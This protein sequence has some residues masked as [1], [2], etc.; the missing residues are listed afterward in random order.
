[1]KKICFHIFQSRTLLLSISLCVSILTFAVGFTP[2]DCGLVVNLKPG[3]QIL[4][5]TMVDTDGD[6]IAETEYFV[7]DYPFHSG[8]RFDYKTGNTLKLIPQ[9][10]GATEPSSVSVWS[11]DTALTRVR[12]E[13]KKDY[14]LGGISYTMW[15]NGSYTL[16]VTA[17]NGFKYQGDLSNDK[18]SSAL[19][20]VVFVIP[21]AFESNTSLDPNNTLGK[22][23]LFDGATGVGF[24]GM[25]YREVFW[26]DIPR[27]NM[28]ISYTNASVLGF[29][30]TLSDYK[31]SDNAETAKPGQA[32]YA[33]ADNK[34]K[35]TKRTLFRLYILNEP[36]NTCPD[37][38]FFAH[39]K[40]D[41]LKYRRGPYEKEKLEWKDS[42]A[43]KKV[44]SMDRLECMEQVGSTTIYKTNLMRMPEKDSAYFYV[45]NRNKYVEE[46]DAVPLG[47]NGAV[48]MFTPLSELRIYALKDALTAFTPLAGAMGRMVVDIASGQDNLGVAFEPAGYFLRTNSGVNVRMVKGD[49]GKWTS[50]EMWTITEE[51]AA[52]AIKATMFSGP[53]FSLEDRGID[54]PGWSTMV[55]GT[56]VP[57]STGGS[58]IGVSGWAQ[59]DPSNPSANGGMVFVP[60]DK[61]KYISYNNNG[62]FGDSV[63]ETHP[64]LGET[65]VEVSAPRLIEGYRFE[66]WAT[67]PEGTGILYQEGDTVDVSG[68]KVTLYAKAEYEGSINIAISF[69]HPVDGKRYFLTHPGTAAPRYARARHIAD[70]TNT[71]QGM[72][73]AENV[74]PNYLTSYLIVG[75]NSI[76][77]E[78]ADGEYVFDPHRMTVYGHEDSLTFYEHF[79]PNTE[80]YAGLYYTYPNTILANNTWAGLFKSSKGWPEPSHPCIENTKLSSTHYLHG[81]EEKIT[82]SERSNSDAPNISYNAAANQFDGISGTGTDFTLSG[83]GVVDAHYVILPDTTEEWPAD[84]TF[85]YHEG[86]QTN[87]PVW[88]KLI[89]KQLLAQMMLGNE[90]IYFHPNNAKT[91]TTA[92]ELRLSLDYRLTQTFTYI[93]DARV[94]EQHVV[95]A[96]DKPQMRET[97]NDFQRVIVSG[98]NSPKNVTYRGNYIDMCDTIRIRLQPMG[99]SRIKEYYGWWKDGAEGLHIAADGSRYRDIIVRTKTYHYAPAETKIVLTPEY[100][101]YALSPLRD[102]KSIIRFTMAKVT[103]H[104]LLDTENNPIREE[105]ITSEDLTSE[106]RLANSY[107]SFA[108]GGRYYSVDAEGTLTRNVTIVTREDNHNA[109]NADTL[110]VSG[111]SI[112]IDGVNYAI[113]E[114]RVPLAQSSLEKNELI[115]SAEYAG[116]RYFIMAG[117]GSNELI[118]RQYTQRGNTLYQLNTYNHLR[119]GSEDAA[120]SNT[121][122]I[123]PWKFSYV[124]DGVTDGQTLQR[125]KFYMG[126]EYG[127]NKGFALDGGTTP[128]ALDG[129]ESSAS[130]LTYRY[131]TVYLNTNTNFEER[132]RIKY[133]MN[134]WL[135]FS[136]DGSGNPSLSLQAD[137]T[138]ATIFSWGYL[139]EEYNLQNNGAYPDKESLEFTY[140]SDPETSEEQSVKAQYKAYRE[141]T[142]L[143]N[144]TLTYCGRDERTAWDMLI[145]PKASGGEWLTML[146]ASR[147]PDS[148]FAG[149]GI[150]SGLSVSPMSAFTTTVTDTCASPILTSAP[151]TNIVDT[152]LVTLSLQDGAPKYGFKGD[153]SKFKSVDDAQ[154]KIPLIRRTYREEAYDSLVCVVL[155]DEYNYTFPATITET[156]S[157]TFTLKTEHRE[158]THIL[159]VYGESVHHTETTD[160]D[161]AMDLSNPS[162]AEIR[163]VDEYGNTPTWCRIAG[164][165]AN[166]LTMECTESGIRAPRS[167]YLYFAYMVQ[168]DK[169]WRFVNFRITL[170]QPSHFDYANNQVLVPSTGASGDPLVNGRQQVHEN[171][172]ILYY[173][174]PSNSITDPDQDVELPVRERGFYG[175][176]RWYRIGKDVNG[177]DVTDTDVPDSL[178]R[179]VPRN[180]G[181]YNFPYR[182]IGDSV[183]VDPN[184]PSA[185]KK[186][187][188]MGR[189]TVFHYPSRDY[190]RNDPPAKSP[191]VTPPTDKKTLT[192]AVDISNYYDN[193]PLS[194][195]HVNQVDTAVLDTIRII[196]EPTLSLREVF[197][198]HPWTEMA[199]KLEGY[200]DTIASGYRNQRYMEDHTVMAPTGARLLLST[201]QRYNYANLAKGNHSES[202]LGYYMRDD[203]WN[204]A[205]W[206]AERKD[207]MI[208]AAGWDAD[209]NWYTYNPET[210]AYSPCS[211][212]ITEG[213][214]FLNVPAR[215]S[216]PAGKTA[217]TV[218]Y[219]LRARS[220]ATTGT[221]GVNEKSSPGAYW[222][223]IC[224]Y[225]VIYHDPR[226]Y[227]PLQEKTVD[228][229]MKALI[230]NDEIEQHYQV[231]ERLNFDYNRPGSDYQVYPHPLP[232]ADASYGYSYPESSE[233]PNNRYH[234][235]F[236]S[237]FANMGEYGI[238]NRIPYSN[239]WHKM[240]Q[241]G[242]AA[243]GYMIYCDGM[244]SA[245]QVAAISLKAK[246]CEGQKMYFSG[247]VGNPSN[248]SGKSNPNFLFS[249]QGSHNGEDWIDITSYMTGDVPP[250]NKW[251]QIYF[252]ITQEGDYD[253]F[254]VRIYNMSSDNDGNDFIIDDMC[255]FA[256]KPPLIAYQANTTCMNAGENDSITHVV[257]RVDYKGFHTEA[258]NDVDVYYT[259]Q[260][261]EE[262]S[263]DTTY[264]DPMDGYI[265][266]KTSGD[267]RY[268]VVHMPLRAFEPAHEDS[269]F[270]NLSDLVEKFENSLSGTPFREGYIYENLDE[271]IRPVLYLIHKAKMT[272]TYRYKVRMSA[273]FGDLL[274]SICAMTSDLKVSNRM[275]LELNGKEQDAKE[276][277]GMCANTTYDISLRVKGSLL[278]DSLAPAEINGSCVNDWLLYGDTAEA[279]S[280]ATYGYKYSDIVKVITRILR[281][282]PTSGTNA[283]QF[284]RNL[285]EV[286]RN[287]MTRMAEGVEL[288]TEDHPYDVLSRLVNDGKLI[289]YRPK[290]T[291]TATY[292][293]SLQYV[294]FPIVGTGSDAMLDMAVEVCPTPIFVK[295]KPTIGGKAPMIIGG[296]KAGEEL[297]KEPPVIL[298][299]AADANQEIGIRIDSI[300]NNVAIDTITLLSTND[301]EYLQGIH[302]LE[303]TPDRIFR[304]GEANYG[305]YTKGDTLL[306]SPASVNNYTMRPGYSYTFGIGMMTN[307]GSPTLGESECRVGTVPFTLS[308]VPD[309]LRWD[310]KSADNNQWND[311]NNWIGINQQNLPIHEDAHFVPLASTSVVIAP[312]GDGLPYPE[313]P[314]EIAAEDSVKQTGF[315]YNTCNAIRFMAGTAMSKQQNLQYKDVIV[316][317]SI[318]QNKWSFRS[319]P[320][321]GMLSG[322][323]FL[324]NAD[325]TW[326]TSPWEVGPFDANGRNYTTGNASFWLSMYNR[327]I[328]HKGNDSNVK[329]STHT[330]TAEWTQVT[331]SMSY[332]LAV[333]QGWAVFARTAAGKGNP[334]APD[335]SVRLPKND[336]I[337]YYY[338][339]SGDKIYTLYEHDLRTK[340]NDYA[341][342]SDKTGKLIYHPEGNKA[343]YT[344]TNA[345]A[346]ELFVFGNPTMGYIDI[347]CFIADNPGVAQ[348]FDYMDTSGKSSILTTVVKSRADASPDVIT[349][350]LRYL[351][352][353]HA[354]VLT[355]ASGTE[356]NLKLY[357]NR[358][359]TETSQV[360]RPLAA[361]PAS[362]P[363]RASMNAP[364]KGIMTV[365]AVNDVDS[366]CV[367]RLL[368]GQG[369]HDAIRSGEDAV[370]MTINIGNFSSSTP[371]T[372]FNLYAAE[373]GY[374][375]STDLRNEVVNVPVS[376]Y[377]S[378]LPYEPVTHLWFT[379]VN[380]IDGELVLYDA[381]MDSEQPII[382]GICLDIETP[383]VNHQNRYYIRRSGYTPGEQPTNPVA[384]GIGSNDSETPVIK[385]I[386]DGN[387]LILRDGHL[388]T[389]FG[390]KIR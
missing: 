263:T 199:A 106:L 152:L 299:N 232:W 135:K 243:N 233:L 186:L 163:L 128:S 369:Y 342:G 5:S 205:G 268:G 64:M 158:G 195:K 319:A 272:P 144:N 99:T 245:G 318:P 170:S 389:M 59:I 383:S 349:N 166:T 314:D 374:G 313:L 96:D 157:H 361:N 171:K 105:I 194:M 181:K 30:T 378:D 339:A 207:T 63:P 324:S 321:A 62:H 387:V 65:T 338:N 345:V 297:S 251:S 363:R 78:C 213:D 127:I 111:M 266:E 258:F 388:Y 12:P 88:S 56:D 169:E 123:T 206:S 8:G 295:L 175:W 28:P 360:V 298:A 281:V 249:V 134:Q 155:N 254:R 379:G 212:K 241:H 24:A 222:F 70:W 347:W 36:L 13:D 223:N 267:V 75:N 234:N 202:L 1:M 283:N 16:A 84:I 101:T 191:L 72:A 68:G 236:A 364:S 102:Q 156:E 17:K 31:Y 328:V 362:S 329:D 201:E 187:V 210:G 146:T 320:V 226:M 343:N 4:L 326:H 322:D 352:P 235:D 2:T 86:E 149:R 185:G 262:G 73:N 332:S 66:G 294:I 124:G 160:E 168:V 315:Q 336:D 306:M 215:S 87:E 58:V 276:I 284:A 259:V 107:C 293:D 275:T 357:T 368:I 288:D 142:M 373:D 150:S 237:N 131:D 54:I 253:Y 280:V 225:T 192:Y 367:S 35:P 208:W 69:I 57:V 112:T 27:Y 220:V 100:E 278:R 95:V 330:A 129:G 26:L 310:P 327:E 292:G 333:A 242:G 282:E 71:W 380:N 216:L 10:N 184:D 248:Q 277:V 116:K 365:T 92:Q 29:N 3:D 301:P 255:I 94:E 167:A 265:N 45:G 103:S 372:P 162:L 82:R 14:A 51:Y 130:M 83:V 344:L 239:Y 79:M 178:W 50:E 42:T 44:Y 80:E 381:L 325:L 90:I 85:D 256:T 141:F 19:C 67:N 20:D 264:V 49:D 108:N 76:C 307:T 261:T 350:Q 114:A 270:S 252:P 382:D 98:M 172:R 174:N 52:L 209:A 136:V 240:E 113:E 132:V 118:F 334:S 53:E 323:I 303:M 250:S 286:S 247:Y 271:E 279:T 138:S 120:N 312:L 386:R 331:N 377:L 291:A 104:W 260:Q 305:Y 356:L 89:G 41:Y 148:R 335:L 143:L 231:L 376:F 21:T 273:D 244:S 55:A 153:W 200:K 385:I 285:T 117:R 173:Y 227:G 9:D 340:R 211:H 317:L 91:K 7:C 204:D 115:W 33:F 177:D 289:M 97:N 161:I 18:G 359:V 164:K 110:V 308:V 39:D 230:T 190:T 179:T 38:Y 371:A 188:T 122:Y 224:R 180:V 15:S 37:S 93:R 46:G 269:I 23:T 61:D 384:T 40:Q 193:L 197:E 151:Y 182:V 81:V 109:E 309:N 43:Y 354:I 25:V 355:A 74:D 77:K 375:L 353:M 218:Y 6:G 341:G 311:P 203:N 287:E 214:D 159:N 219:C 246:L 217:D 290:L 390:Q 32:L 304:A 366:R 228:G 238:I 176:W 316:D 147:I 154:L 196:H 165:T 337:Y 370:L 11:I 346:S 119:K 300:M 296:Y 183:P 60:A 189:Y 125:L 145:K 133:G 274:S 348:E 34:H 121:R 351:P 229:E 48:S 22:G 358:V 221:P 302:T 126:D 139:L 140:H 137:S 257:L 198:L 47:T